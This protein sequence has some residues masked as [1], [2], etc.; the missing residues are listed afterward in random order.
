MFK[1]HEGKLIHAELH[2]N[3]AASSILDVFGKSK[4]SYLAFDRSGIRGRITS[5]MR[6]LRMARLNG[7]QDTFWGTSMV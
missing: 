5:P 4:K 7:T 1:G 6:P 3:D 2:I